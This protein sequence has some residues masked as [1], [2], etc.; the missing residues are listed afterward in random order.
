M[1]TDFASA[2]SHGATSCPA[3]DDDGGP[4]KVCKPDSPAGAAMPLTAEVRQRAVT[5]AELIREASASI[6]R[7][8]REYIRGLYPDDLIL[9]Y[10]AALTA[11]ERDSAI[12]RYEIPSLT[13][14]CL[15]CGDRLDITQGPVNEVT[16]VRV[17]PHC[18]CN[19]GVNLWQSLAERDALLAARATPGT[20]DTTQEPTC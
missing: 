9:S 13:G 3:C 1:L 16:C 7:H 11:A 18:A 2:L 12:A 6:G 19:Q 20:V 8:E 4:C 17:R 5:A 10:E 15:A 14:C